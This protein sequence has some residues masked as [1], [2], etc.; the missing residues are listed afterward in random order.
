MV[1]PKEI[2]DKIASHL[3]LSKMFHISKWS[4]LQSIRKFP[5]QDYIYDL[6]DNNEIEAFLWLIKEDLYVY[7]NNHFFYIIEKNNVKMLDFFIKQFN[8]INAKYISILAVK[9]GNLDIIKYLLFNTPYPAKYFSS[10]TLDTAIGCDNLEIFLFL[11]EYKPHYCR[12]I[13]YYFDLAVSSGSIKILKYFKEQYDFDVSSVSFLKFIKKT[14]S[15]T[16]IRFLYS[17][18]KPEITPKVQNACRKNP[19]IINLLKTIQE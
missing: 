6:I 15:L 17:N 8:I 9:K 13:K 14:N 10:Y 16:S 4:F 5:N 11:M 19:R 2:I 12:N 7:K 3:S 18:F 1:L